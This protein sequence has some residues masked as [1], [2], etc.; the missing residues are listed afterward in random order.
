VQLYRKV[1]LCRCT[2]PRRG[3]AK[4]N[5][6]RTFNKE[7]EKAFFFSIKNIK[8]IIDIILINIKNYNLRCDWHF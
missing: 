8:N 2:V 7:P 3:A 4:I 1:G 5:F 6:T